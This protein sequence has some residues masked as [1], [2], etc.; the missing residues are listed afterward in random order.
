[1]NEVIAAGSALLLAAFALEP[2][3]APIQEQPPGWMPEKGQA[4]V[5]SHETGLTR[6]PPGAEAASK[7]FVE[8]AHGATVAF[9]DGRLEDSIRLAE[10]AASHTR[11]D[12]QWI[13]IEEI[14]I[15]SFSRLGNDPE[16]IASLDVVLSARGCLTEESAA[17]YRQMR[18]AARKR[19]RP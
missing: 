12:R 18:E 5:Y 19:V 15:Q 13:R 6:P 8:A 14:R 4:S 2:V 17:E 10:T 11:S 1:M 3:T 7:S 16:L 9:R